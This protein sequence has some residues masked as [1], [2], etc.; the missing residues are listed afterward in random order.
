M[1]TPK[2]FGLLILPALLLV[3]SCDI[4]N[5]DSVPQPGAPAGGNTVYTLPKSGAVMDLLAMTGYENATGFRVVRQ[6]GHGRVGFIR[7]ATLLY[8]PDTT[9]DVKSDYF[10]LRVSRG[11][12]AQNPAKTDTVV[13]R[14]V[15]RD[16]IPC[17]A[18]AIADGFRTNPDTPLT[19]N[20]LANDRFCQGAADSSSLKIGTNPE[21]GKITIRSNRQ[22]VYTPDPDYEGQ[23]VFT[24]RICNTNNRCSEAP[25][26][27]LVQRTDSAQCPGAVND[28]Y[29][30]YGTTIGL[31]ILDNDVFCAGALDSNSVI[32]IR[33]PQYGTLQPV[34]RQGILRYTPQNANPPA[35]MTDT[36]VYRVC[37][38]DGKTC[39]EAT[40]SITQKPC[41]I[42]LRNDSL[43][44]R[45]P[46]DSATNNA[47]YTS[48][49]HIRFRGN[50]DVSCAIQGYNW[51]ISQPPAHGTAT[52]RDNEFIIYKAAAGYK[53]T[54]VIEYSYCPVGGAACGNRAKIYIRIE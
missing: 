13:I 12:S 32:L 14:F 7:N 49:L 17:A 43:T 9:Q 45:T 51:A 16:S 41:R 54:D 39:G 4:L 27:I 29:L 42:V 5:K 11:D 31:R 37:T 52:F 8:T 30:T 20:V 25:V 6:P 24:Y 40:V 44:Y 50:D 38:K 1:K 48:G 35:E 33:Q 53:G 18:G 46:V 15:P 28:T 22:L 47:A 21:H 2:T 26:R 36:F 10:L 23:D 34:G 3:C 19:M